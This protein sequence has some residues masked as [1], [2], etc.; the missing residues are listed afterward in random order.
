MCYNFSKSKVE[1][2]ISGIPFISVILI[3]SAWSLFCQDIQYS[4]L[5]KHVDGLFT[6]MNEIS[7]FVFFTEFMLS[8]LFESNF[9]GSF[10]FWVDLIS[11][12]SVIPDVQ[13]IWNPVV[14]LFSGGQVDPNVSYDYDQL[15]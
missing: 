7:F 14:D 13:I 12:I 6:L 5:D 15:E 10:F 2:F 11:M 3:L 9:I 1:P 4:A 8:S